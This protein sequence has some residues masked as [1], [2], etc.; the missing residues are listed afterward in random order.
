MNSAERKADD[1]ALKQWEQEFSALGSVETHPHPVDKY[2]LAHFAA[3][4]PQRFLS[5]V[6]HLSPRD[7]EIILC[8]A[9]LQKGPT[10]IGVLFGKA[11]HRAQEDLHKA[12]HKLAGLIEFGQSPALSAIETILCRSVLRQFGPHSL[13]AAM[14]H[15]ATTRDF[16]EV[17]RSLKLRGLRQHM[18]RTFR[19]LHASPDREAGL[20]AGWILWLVDGSNP[21]AKGWRK[22]RRTGREYQLGPTVFHCT[23]SDV[24][25]LRPRANG[26][27]GQ[28]QRPDVV[29]FSRR[30]KFM[31]RGANV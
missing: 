6:K 5:L 8:F 3:D 22:R 7:A 1:F 25:Q 28:G 15:Y 14:L 24:D 11:G 13:G 4:D 16:R 27:G 19:A 2:E 31:L 9:V 30:M 17:T 26:K 29:K 12:A 18:L 10:D 21:Q 20:L 23:G